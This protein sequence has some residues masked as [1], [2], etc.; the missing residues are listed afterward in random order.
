M[1]LFLMLSI[2][3]ITVVIAPFNR[4]AKT[5]ADVVTDINSNN[6]ALMNNIPGL[7]NLGSIPA[8]NMGPYSIR[9]YRHPFCPG[10]IA[11]LPLYRNAEG[12]HIL[13]TKINSE[14]PRY[15]FLINGKIY[16]SFPQ[17]VFAIQKANRAILKLTSN[18]IKPAPP[19]F[20]FAE[21]GNCKLA[22]KFV[23]Y[24]L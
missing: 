12:S 17:F 4:I 11:I 19:A 14:K 16:S 10:A 1:K 2:L 7:I 21:D 20:A 13:R 22:E 5:N 8:A 15:G 24:T 18:Q 6:S 23:R 9:G 3:T